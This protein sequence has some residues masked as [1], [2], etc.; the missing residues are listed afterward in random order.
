MKDKIATLK[1]HV[2]RADAAGS[3]AHSSACCCCC[4][5]RCS[6][7]ISCDVVAT[8]LFYTACTSF[9]WAY[10]PAASCHVSSKR[11]QLH[12][13]MLLAL[14]PPVHSKLC[15]FHI[16]T[17][18]TVLCTWLFLLQVALQDFPQSR[19]DC[20]NYKFSKTATICNS[21]FCI[22][23]RSHCAR[24]H[25]CM[26]QCVQTLALSAPVTLRKGGRKPGTVRWSCCCWSDQ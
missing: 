9:V 14:P 25:T 4:K 19:P 12:V 7:L 5:L 3:N 16:C 18:R 22:Q 17:L 20:G 11:S 1:C 21:R 10:T 15:I 13:M 23:V 8:G 24:L 26:M 6:A 2:S